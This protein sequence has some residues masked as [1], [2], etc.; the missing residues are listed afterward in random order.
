M[1]S[2]V[3]FSELRHDLLWTVFQ[4][5]EQLLQNGQYLEFYIGK[6]VKRL[7]ILI[8][9]VSSLSKLFFVPKLDYSQQVG[10]SHV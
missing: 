6:S 8:A 9:K 4:Y 5:V 10:D 2:V 3:I 7:F 1:L